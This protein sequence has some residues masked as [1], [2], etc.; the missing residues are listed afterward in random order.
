MKKEQILSEYLSYLET[1]KKSPRWVYQFIDATSIAKEDF[2]DHFDDINQ[3]ERQIWLIRLNSTI[4]ILFDDPGYQDYTVREKLLAFYF[5]LFENL[6]EGSNAFVP[7]LNNSMLPRITPSPLKDF[8]PVFLKFA[9]KLLE[10]G[11]NSK[12]IEFRPLL[13]SYYADAIWLQYLFLL[14][15]WKNDKSKGHLATDEAVERSTNLS[16]DLM[17][18][19][20]IDATLGF[21]K[22]LYRNKKQHIL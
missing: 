7:M 9:H 17:G 18:Y 1:V 16:F 21:I 19:T 20:P 3:L 10:E 12:E 5:T 6:N 2:Y 8:K 11:I 4:Q 14:R 13:T 15:F 22:F